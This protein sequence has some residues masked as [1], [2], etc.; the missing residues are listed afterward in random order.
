M[1]ILVLFET[2]WKC[3]LVAA[4]VSVGAS[5]GVSIRVSVGVSS[6]V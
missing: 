1:N 2:Y 3:S 5:I 6:K 4:E